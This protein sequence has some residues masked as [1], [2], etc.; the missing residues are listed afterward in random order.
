LSAGTSDGGLLISKI[1]RTTVAAV[2]LCLSWLWDMLAPPIQ[3]ALDRLPLQRLKQAVIRF[4]DRLP[5]YATLLVFLIPIIVI[6]PLKILAVW[7][8]AK[9]QFAVGLTTF[10]GAEVLR[11]SLVAF[12]F[13][14]CRDKLLSIG[15][16]AWAY[17]WFV[18]AHEW[19]HHQVAPVVAAA[20]AWLQEAGLLGGEQGV[21]RR[22]RAFWR[23]ARRQRST[24]S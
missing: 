14:V 12:L 19:A 7:L 13:K 8:F 6:E 5:P 23:Y 10:I 1:L 21:G 11:F 2:F 18:W 9:G 17:G 15:W 4:M 3:W 20:R 22:L 24:G 16:F